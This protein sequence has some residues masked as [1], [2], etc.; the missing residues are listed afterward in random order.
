MLQLNQENIFYRHHK[1]FRKTSC[2]SHIPEQL[3]SDQ[4]IEDAV[5]SALRR[6]VE[7]AVKFG[8]MKSPGPSFVPECQ[9]TSISDNDIFGRA[10]D[11]NAADSD[12]ELEHE[13]DIDDG[14][15]DTENDDI[16]IG[17]LLN[18]NLDQLEDSSDDDDNAESENVCEDLLVVSTGALGVKSREA[19]EV[20]EDSIWVKVSDGNGRPALIKKSSLC[21]LLSSGKAKMSGDRLQRVQTPLTTHKSQQSNEGVTSPSREEYVSVGDWCAFWDEKQ[22]VAVGQIMAFSY[23][24]GSTKKDQSYSLWSAPTSP[25]KENAKGLGCFCSWF[26]VARNGVLKPISMD[27]HGNYNLNLY[28][29][30][31]PRPKLSSNALRLPCTLKDIKKCS[32]P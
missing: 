19:S 16:N 18:A 20:P 9:L 22:A 3:P 24:S 2:T 15:V 10:E 14:L 31:L 13:R 26:S 27:L 8:M 6:A 30:T 17:E 7:R 21:W 29:C 23:L 5:A 28:I 1:A 25:P 32:Q 12:E 11:R 4:E